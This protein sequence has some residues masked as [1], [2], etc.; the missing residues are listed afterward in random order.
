MKIEKL[1]DGSFVFDGEGNTIMFTNEST[2]RGLELKGFNK[3]Q[4]TICN[5]IVVG[6]VKKIKKIYNIV[7]SKTLLDKIKRFIRHKIKINL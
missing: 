6:D 2:K 4:Y 5:M 3:E 7:D 1:K